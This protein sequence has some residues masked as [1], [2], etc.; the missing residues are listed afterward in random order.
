MSSASASHPSPTTRPAGSSWSGFLIAGFVLFVLVLSSTL[1]TALY[2]SYTTRYGF[3][4][5][6]LTLIFAAYIAGL[7]V[8]LAERIEA[9]DEAKIAIAREPEARRERQVPAPAVARDND[10][11]GGRSPRCSAFPTTHLSPETQSLSPT[12]QVPGQRPSAGVEHVGKHLERV[13]RVPT[14]WHPGE[15]LGHIPQSC[16]HPHTAA[17][18]EASSSSR[19]AWGLSVPDMTPHR[20]RCG[21]RPLTVPA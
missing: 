14:V 17:A 15:R 1:P 6:V 2:S 3:G 13:R 18:G 21:V 9:L 5:A 10:P 7:L 20:C 16:G 11:G 4:S 12:G 19:V 8:V